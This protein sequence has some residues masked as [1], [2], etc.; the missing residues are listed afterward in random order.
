MQFHVPQFIE[1]EA[2]IFGPLSFRQFVFLAGGV[3]FLA[4][5]WFWVSSILAIVVGI[6]IVA[7]GAALAF[8]KPY[9]MPFEKLLEAAF[10]F[11]TSRHLY[12]WQ[13]PTSKAAPSAPQGAEGATRPI[14]H[15]QTTGPS[16]LRELA[17]RLDVQR[18]S[19]PKKEEE[20]VKEKL[21]LQL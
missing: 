16:K 21:G 15:I 11:F 9:G 20:E 13:K 17:F 1:L 10:W 6:P 7:L 4:M 5:L 18:R 14:P 12:L 2:K 3:G 19:R 8:W